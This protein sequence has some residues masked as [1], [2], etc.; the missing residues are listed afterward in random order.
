MRLPELRFLWLHHGVKPSNL[1]LNFLGGVAARRPSAVAFGHLLVL[2][3]RIVLEDL[4]LEDPDL[5]AAGAEGR[6]RGR[7]PVVDVGAQGVQ[8]HAAFTVPLHA[9][10]FGAAEAPRA[11]DA[12]AFGAQTHRRLNGALHGATERDAALELLRDRFGNQRRIE[13]GLADF[14]DVDDDVGSRDVGDL[15]AQLVDVGALLAD[16]DARTRRVD[17]HAAL[18]VRPLDHDL[19]DRRLLELLV[20]DLTDLDVLVQQLAVLVLAGKP[21]RIPGPVDAETKP[22]RIDFL[23]HRIPPRL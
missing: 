10:D 1:L 20:Q 6:E 4:A 13:F 18:L 16:H 22:D 15:L 14:D 17:R 5:D 21:A 12:D 11:V 19:G 3:H 23:T 2:G 7:N 8:R 9:R